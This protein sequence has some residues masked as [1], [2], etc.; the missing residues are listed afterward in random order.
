MTELSNEFLEDDSGSGSDL[1][2][3]FAEGWEAYEIELL[4]G[5]HPVCPYDADTA[6][7]ASWWSGY[8]TAAAEA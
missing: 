3:V 2:A 8:L 1:D 6:E 5:E 4:T 7:N